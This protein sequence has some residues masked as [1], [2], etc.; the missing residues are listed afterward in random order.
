MRSPGSRLLD[1]SACEELNFPLAA[2]EA[3]VLLLG[4]RAVSLDVEG[5]ALMSA[6]TQPTALNLGMEEADGVRFLARMAADGY[7]VAVSDGGGEPLQFLRRL[8]P[9]DGAQDHGEAIDRNLIISAEAI[10]FGLD[11]GKVYGD[12]LPGSLYDYGRGPVPLPSKQEITA[13]GKSID[14]LSGL[15]RSGDTEYWLAWEGTTKG[16][17]TSR[18]KL[19][20]SPNS[21][22]KDLSRALEC[23]NELPP[24]RGMKVAARPGDHARPDYCV[25]YLRHDADLP[26]VAIGLL[27]ALGG[28][29]GRGVPFS[30]P[31]DPDGLVSWG[32]DPEF[33]HVDD[34]S[35]RMGMSNR[36]ARHVS[37]AVA[38]TQDRVLQRHEVAWRLC[39]DG[40]AGHGCLPIA[41]APNGD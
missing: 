3:G 28:M 14:M 33:P 35:H 23:L 15:K 37:A 4:G 38:A 25:L 19:F 26:V 21:P 13:F 20:I 5:F 40:Y 30:A 11:W 41:G 27:K 10:E 12:E 36:I 8:P 24:L 17:P 6:L 39:M 1:A 32:S 34:T 29:V 18:L 2:E 9:W 22:L 16:R 31:L 7:L